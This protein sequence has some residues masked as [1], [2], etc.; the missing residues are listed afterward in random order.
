M[1]QQRNGLIDFYRFIFALI[2]VIHHAMWLDGRYVGDIENKVF[3]RGGYSAVEFFFILSGYLLSKKA[4]DNQMNDKIGELTWNEITKR[5][6]ALYPSFI[7]SNILS[8]FSYL[9][10]SISFR[11]F[12]FTSNCSGFVMIS[13]ILL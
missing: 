4:Y 12:F 8:T 10:I 11:Y 6:K 5:V 7:I 2:I 9:L 13:F 3:F 1:K